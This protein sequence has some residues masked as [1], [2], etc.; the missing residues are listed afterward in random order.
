MNNRLSY[1]YCVFFLKVL[2]CVFR[3]F[4]NIP[5]LAGKKH[6]LLKSIPFAV[7]LACFNQRRLTFDLKEQAGKAYHAIS[8][9]RFNIHSSGGP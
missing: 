6:V 2:T 5:N 7:G 4:H 9:L 3:K 8:R 1:G